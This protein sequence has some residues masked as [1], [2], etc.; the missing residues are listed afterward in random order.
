MA[1]RSA[2]RVAVL[3]PVEC[4]ARCVRQRSE[5]KPC[6]SLEP[7]LAPLVKVNSMRRKTQRHSRLASLA[8]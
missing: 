3:L 7:L 8:N 2:W 5:A 4:D 6:A 1:L